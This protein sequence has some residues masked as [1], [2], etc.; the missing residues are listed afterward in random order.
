M[1]CSSETIGVIAAA[2]AKAQGELSNP[3]RS[4][5]ATIR[6][7]FPRE[8]A[9]TFRYASLASGLDIVRKSLGQHEIATIQTTRIDEATG[10][11]RLT[12]LLAHTSGEWISSDWPVCA[13]SETAAPHRM[14]AALTYARRYALFTLVG[15]AGEDD[16]DAPDLEP[17]PLKMSLD[18]PNSSNGEV[19][20]GHAQTSGASAGRRRVPV[21]QIAAPILPTAQSAVERDRLIAEL[22]ALH[23]SEAAA[24]WAHRSLKAKHSLTALDAQIIE[25]AFQTKL[26]ALEDEVI[27]ELPGAVQRLSEAHAIQ[28]SP[29]TPEPESPS[30]SSRSGRI[31][32]KTIRLRDGDHRKFVSTQPCLV[33]GRSPADAHHLRFAQPRALGRKVS[34]EFTVPLC[35]AHHRELHRRGN[36]AAWWRSIKIEPLP[37]AYRLWQHSRL[38]GS[39]AKMA[40]RLTSISAEE[41]NS[42]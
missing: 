41:G 13:S 38:N 9:R 2:L 20:N 11:I 5:T 22:G 31:P 34:D 28:P 37:V 4:L 14:G 18:R 6:S 26:V 24:S 42:Q 21:S 39:A 33:C 40:E 10:Q 30:A 35:R 19:T 15:I 25:T 12:T 36:E 8:A 3:E 29:D 1:H 7:P 32:A 16:L 17:A 23:S 27:S